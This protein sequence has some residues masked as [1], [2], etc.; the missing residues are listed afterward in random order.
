MNR[1]DRDR[2][3][4]AEVFGSIKFS[5]KRAEGPSRPWPATGFAVNKS[6]HSGTALADDHKL[7]RSSN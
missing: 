7:V 5:G 2:V 1:R 4:A 6:T 3:S